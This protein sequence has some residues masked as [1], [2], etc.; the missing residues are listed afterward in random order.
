[1]SNP[2]PTDTGHARSPRQRPPTTNHGHAA[3][4]IRG[5][6]SDSRRAQHRVATHPVQPP[7]SPPHQPRQRELHTPRLTNGPPYHARDATRPAKWR[8]RWVIP[9]QH[10]AYTTWDAYVRATAGAECRKRILFRD[11]GL[12]GFAAATKPG[13]GMR[14]CRARVERHGSRRSSG[15]A[16]PP[17]RDAP[18]SRWNRQIWLR[19]QL[20]TGVPSLHRGG[21]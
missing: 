19:V 10:L 5:Y 3:T 17:P 2:P 20:H 9:S 18:M 13:T 7:H 12:S 14:S 15:T 6:Q 1:M 8:C 21:A 4:R 16:A 11:I